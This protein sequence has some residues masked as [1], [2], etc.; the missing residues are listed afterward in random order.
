MEDALKICAIAVAA[1]LCA[2]VVKKQTPE[3]GIVLTLVA[4]AIILGLSLGAAERVRSLM[5]TLADTAGLSPA[6][7]APVIKT[8]G[9][10]IVTRIAAEVCR[11]AKESGVASFV[12]T[13]G[14]MLAL[15]VSLPLLE[16]V[17][18]TITGFL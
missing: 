7:L 1:A 4:G 18:R 8:A 16:A 6:V 2:V 14:A 9:I 5:D 11:D 12:E 13:A 15:A 17:L 3:I 10:A